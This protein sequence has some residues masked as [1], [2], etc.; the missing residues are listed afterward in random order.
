MANEVVGKITINNY[1]KLGQL[2][3]AWASGNKATPNSIEEFKAQIEEMRS[4]GEPEIIEIP[5]NIRELEV[6]QQEEGF[7]K[8][9]V[10]RK[11]L[12]EKTYRIIAEQGIYPNFP[13]FYAKYGFK[14]PENASPEELERFY[15]CR[16]GHYSGPDNQCG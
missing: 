6:I 1:E 4:P 2:I 15:T 3:R 9:L 10:P 13:D 11:E 8:F 12:M 16:I 7:L 14:F 5:N